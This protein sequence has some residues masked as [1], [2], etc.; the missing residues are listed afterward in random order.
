MATADRQVHVHGPHA[1][2]AHLSVPEEVPLRPAR[3][4][5]VDV[6][7]DAEVAEQLQRVGHV[8]E[9]A[10]LDLPAAETCTQPSSDGQSRCS[11]GADTVKLDITI[12]TCSMYW[13]AN[14]HLCSRAPC[15]AC[16]ALASND[17]LI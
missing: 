6:A 8:P 10:A 7:L 16:D 12:Q 3:A 11:C 2:A 13:G 1:C 15:R 9:Q 17:S 4:R 5:G 14:A